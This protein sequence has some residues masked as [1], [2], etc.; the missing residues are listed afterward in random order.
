MQVFNNHEKKV[1]EAIEHEVKRKNL[2]HLLGRIAFPKE[3]YLQVRNNKKV[4]TERSYFPGYMMVEC[5]FCDE[6]YRLITNVDGV[7]A[8]LG[9]KT[10]SP[11]KEHEVRNMLE[12]MDEL[13]EQE[14]VTEVT[15]KVGQK[16]KIVDG[17]FASMFG[18]ITN[19][20]SDKQRVMVDMNIFNRITALELSYEQV[21]VE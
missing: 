2:T 3:K 8:I 1:K 5:D 11:M 9:G 21:V 20:I 18:T 6:L 15:L 13:A 16:V 7:V 4:K 14:L 10:A 17:P 12:K 19:V